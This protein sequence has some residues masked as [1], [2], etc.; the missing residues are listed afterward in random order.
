MMEEETVYSWKLG[1]DGV[2][3]GLI[4]DVSM[5]S[6]RSL[7]QIEFFFFFYK[8]SN[9]LWI[10]QFQVRQANFSHNYSSSPVSPRINVINNGDFVVEFHAVLAQFESA[11]NHRVF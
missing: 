5:T 10:D 9:P 1:R 3:M 4:Y 8:L 11:Y 6:N 7:L 2:E